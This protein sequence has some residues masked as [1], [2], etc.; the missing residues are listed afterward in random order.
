MDMN[1]KTSSLLKLV[2]SPLLF[3]IQLV[4]TEHL[5]CTR[6]A[7]SCLGYSGGR[8]QNAERKSYY[9][10]YSPVE[11]GRHESP[12][13]TNKCIIFMPGKLNDMVP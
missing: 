1:F 9:E 4:L 3:F 7:A 2:F 5:L 6:H 13:P 11:D 12:S 10:A 8:K